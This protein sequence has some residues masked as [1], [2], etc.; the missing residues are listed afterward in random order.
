MGASKQ[1]GQVWENSSMGSQ[2]LSNGEQRSNPNLKPEIIA[3]GEFII[4]TGRGI[5]GILVAERRMLR[6]L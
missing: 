1:G 3:P 2:V 4:S 5:P 6:C